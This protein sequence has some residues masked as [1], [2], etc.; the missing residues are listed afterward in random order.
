[1]RALYREFLEQTPP[2]AIHEPRKSMDFLLRKV[3]EVRVGLDD[4][5]REAVVHDK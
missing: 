5:K 3:A 2:E 4:L 1:M